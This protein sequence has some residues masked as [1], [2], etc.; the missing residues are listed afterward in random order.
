VPLRCVKDRSP[1]LVFL[2]FSNALLEV[3][4]KMNLRVSKDGRI[5]CEGVYEIGDEDSL[6][7]ACADVWNRLKERRIAQS[8][9]IGALYDSLE[10][11]VLTDLRG[12]RFDFL[13]ADYG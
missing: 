8:T 1:R 10:D 11:G 4:M 2:Y 9:S 3:G 12:A 7:R 13:E 6:G 5:L